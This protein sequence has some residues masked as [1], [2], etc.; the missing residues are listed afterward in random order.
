MFCDFC[1]SGIHPKCCDPP[2]DYVPKGD[3]ACRLCQNEI[4]TSSN[5]SLIKTLSSS[6][7]TSSLSTLSRRSNNLIDDNSAAIMSRPVAQLIDGMSSFFLPNKD[8]IK[9]LRHQSIHKTMKY[10]RENEIIKSSNTKL[11]KKLHSSSLDSKPTRE[12]NKLKNKLLART[13]LASSKTKRITKRLVNDDL[14]IKYEKKDKTCFN[15][16]E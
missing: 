12:N 11:P 14:C 2:L 9:N 1:D 13:I 6:S 10:L 4:S 8:H 16:T 7:S 15:N 3:F 5:K